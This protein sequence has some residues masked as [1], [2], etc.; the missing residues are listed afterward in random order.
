MTSQRRE[1]YKILLVKW[2]SACLLPNDLYT[3][4]FFFSSF[5][6]KIHARVGMHKPT[7]AC[8]LSSEFVGSMTSWHA[9]SHRTTSPPRVP[10]TSSLWRRRS[11]RRK[12]LHRP[13]GQRPRDPSG[14][15]MIRQRIRKGYFCP[16]RMNISMMIR[17]EKPVADHH[18]PPVIMPD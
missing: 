12:A 3:F 10:L 16:P 9:T 7:S 5:A 4:S 8:L 15:A 1:A 14:P 13:P 2:K 11:G 6:S 17:C 18:Q